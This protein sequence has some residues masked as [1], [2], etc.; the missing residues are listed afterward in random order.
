MAELLEPYRRRPIRFL[1]VWEEA[2]WRIKVY[3]ITL[4]GGTLRPELLIA[5][6]EAA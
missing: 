1:E 4:A 5:A 6:K 3:S 2:A